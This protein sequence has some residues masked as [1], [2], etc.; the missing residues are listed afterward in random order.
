MKKQKIIF[1]IILLLPVLVAC[2][3]Q[4]LP[5]GGGETVPDGMVEV[6]P[7]LSGMFGDIPRGTAG[8]KATTRAYDDNATT[9]GKL[10][11]ILRLPGGSTVWLIAEN[12]KDHSL[13]KKSYVVYNSGDDESLSYLIPCRVDDD[14]NMV[15]AED[16]PLYLRTGAKYRFSA[17]SPARK[18]NDTAFAAGKASLM[19]RNGDYLYANDCRYTKTSPREVTVENEASGEHRQIVKLNPM[20]NQT[21]QLKFR[22]ESGEGVHDLDMMS[23]GIEI[24][25]LQG[26][27]PDGVAWH[28]SQNSDDEPIDLAHG[29]KT[30]VYQQYE[31]TTDGQG[32]FIIDTD[33][34][35]MWSISKPLIVLFNIKV[36]GI[37]STFEMMINEKDFKAGYS[38]GYRGIIS[39]NGGVTVLNWQSVSWE[40]DIELP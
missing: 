40:T 24:A 9:D 28:M 5:D 14:G 22:I 26:D 21:A 20:I 19:M 38:Y 4:D 37:P 12:E 6:C 36:N 18:L 1:R 10:G 17:I 29:D 31:Y 35:P 3:G 34:I 15:S 7:V 27:S 25:G 13:E 11:T 8:D 33:I 23:A 2:S 16:I 30:G 32:N 39:I